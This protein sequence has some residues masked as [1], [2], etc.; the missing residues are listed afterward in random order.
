LPE[1]QPAATHSFENF[2]ERIPRDVGE[3]DG[4]EARITCGQE[5]VHQRPLG[6]QI[7]NMSRKLQQA[8]RYSAAMA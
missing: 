7:T 5:P 2:R 1:W 3:I 4:Y 8:T 6:K